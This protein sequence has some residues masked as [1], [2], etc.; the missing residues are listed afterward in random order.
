M[1]KE[2]SVI[3]SFELYSRLIRYFFGDDE[4]E[5]E[6]IMDALE[7]KTHKLA[8]NEKYHKRLMQERAGQKESGP[9]Q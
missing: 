1:A 6:F 2:K 9:E 5:K 8:E 3:I 7:Q 4:G